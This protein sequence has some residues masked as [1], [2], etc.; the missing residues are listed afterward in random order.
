[1][2]PRNL[3]EVIDLILTKIPATEDRKR[4]RNMLADIQL[5][6]TCTA[7]EAMYR[8]WEQVDKLLWEHV[9][10]IGN[11]H[12]MPWEVEVWEIW[13]GVERKLAR[14]T[15]RAGRRT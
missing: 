13:S 9:A 1:M 7:P 12:A 14:R 6:V 10:W 8:R 5:S 3:G 2:M 11:P 15:S 4:I